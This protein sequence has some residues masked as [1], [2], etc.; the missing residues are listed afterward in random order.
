M[1]TLPDP[2]K[3]PYLRAG[4]YY[5]PHPERERNLRAV[6]HNTRTWADVQRSAQRKA[7]AIL[8]TLAAAAVLFWL[9]ASH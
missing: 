7:R 1:N 8:W 6:A 2:P 9:W 4:G 5:A 3:P